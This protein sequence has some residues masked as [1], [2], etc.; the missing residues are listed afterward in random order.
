VSPYDDKALIQDATLAS[1]DAGVRVLQAY[2]LDRSEIGHVRKLLDYAA[3]PRD[4]VIL[5]L[6]SGVGEFARLAQDSRQ[7]LTLIN[8]NLSE[9][10]L[11]LSQDTHAGICARAEALPLVDSSVD[12]VVMAYTFG[13]CDPAKT[14]GEVRR[15]LKPGGVL[16]F[17]DVSLPGFS[18]RNPL[19][20]FGYRVY[21]FSEL[22]TMFSPPAF[23]IDQWGIPALPSIAH[24]KAIMPDEVFDETFGAV[25]PFIARFIKE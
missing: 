25:W 14:I 21:K 8:L 19:E 7:D 12:G 15:V 10:Q 2:R 20:Q 5:D 9:F 4:A 16:L 13:H 17:Y 24:M 6:G 1:L 18:E 11:G 22:I 3:F 23:T